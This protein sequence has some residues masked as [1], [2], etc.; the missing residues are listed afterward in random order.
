MFAGAKQAAM[1]TETL[2]LVITSGLS[3]AGLFVTALE[4]RRQRRVLRVQLANQTYQG[5]T[6][7]QD[8]F[9]DLLGA[10][11]DKVSPPE[12]R[13]FMIGFFN[14]YSRLYLAHRVGVFPRE[15]WE[16]LRTSLA[17]WVRRPEIRSAWDEF[18]REA[19]AWPTGFVAFVEG[20]LA[21]DDTDAERLWAPEAP[22]PRA[23]EQLR[24]DFGP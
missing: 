23:W 16:D 11:N 3:S 1:E 24:A 21:S 18:S 4:A 10:P 12:W 22:D 13:K 20:E 9:Y 2:T 15:Q 17:Y 5:F 7:Y 19:D 6:V 8:R 14:F